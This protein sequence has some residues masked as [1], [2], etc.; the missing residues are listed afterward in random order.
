MSGI[1][2]SVLCLLCLLI[3]Y[4]ESALAIERLEVEI[5]SNIL[6]IR[7]TTST[8]SPVVDALNAGDRLTV[9]TTDLPDWIKLDDG[10]GF[11][12]I[13]YVN[14]LS[15][16]PVFQSPAEQ[17]ESS[18]DQPKSDSDKISKKSTVLSAP[19]TEVQGT[20]AIAMDKTPPKPQ[21]CITNIENTQLQLENQSKTCRKN[22]QTMGYESCELMFNLVLSSSCNQAATA[23]ISCSANVRSESTQQGLKEQ[24]ELSISGPVRFSENGTSSLLLN[25]NPTTPEIPVTQVQL[26][27]GRCQIVKITQPL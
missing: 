19:Q 9:T 24:A 4:T 20:N 26:N 1:Y 13:H 12:S 5:R 14:V 17:R 23:D 21:S 25:W 2:K 27:N 22:L 3:T 18:S 7:Q 15:R 11:I 8:K 10:R 16:T 6:N